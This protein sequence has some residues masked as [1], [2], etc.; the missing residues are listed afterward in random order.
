M[1]HADDKLEYFSVIN[2][3][4]LKKVIARD[5]IYVQ[6]V[7]LSILSWRVSVLAFAL[8]LFKYTMLSTPHNE[9]AILKEY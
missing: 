9:F 5:V 7:R 8:K 1:I 3:W 4:A 6:L 2:W